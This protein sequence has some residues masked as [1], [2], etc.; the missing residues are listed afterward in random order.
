MYAW[1]CKEM[2]ATWMCV[3]GVMCEAVT[4]G[5]STLPLVMGVV[6]KPISFEQW[7]GLAIAAIAVS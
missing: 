2:S 6:S 7:L 5:L 3:S 1:F 4:M